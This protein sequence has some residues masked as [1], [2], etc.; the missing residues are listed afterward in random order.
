MLYRQK[1]KIG[2]I[3]RQDLQCG[4]G[5]L[6]RRLRME[7]MESRMML[8]ASAPSIDGS[9]LPQSN[10]SDGMQQ[11]FT[12]QIALKS[13]ILEGGY[14]SGDDIATSGGV[15]PPPVSMS[16][17]GLMVHGTNHSAY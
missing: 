16:T 12:L 17:G 3:R 9:L 4:A 2:R 8:S 5:R 7:R 10:E 6:S 15:A 13:P 14:I 11:V 1:S